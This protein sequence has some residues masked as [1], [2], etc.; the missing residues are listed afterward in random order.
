MNKFDLVVIGG[1]P[2]GYP[3]AI[4]MAKKG[5][6][7]A[8]VERSGEV[9]GTC[10]KWGCIPTKALLASAKG[11]HFL[12]TAEEFGLKSNDIGFD[13]DKIQERKIGIT[14]KLQIGIIKLLKKYKVTVFEGMAKLYK[15][16]KVIIENEQKTEIFG[17]RVCVCVGSTPFI[18]P[19]FP[20]NKDLFWS[21]NEALEAK[22]IP[23]KLLIVGGGVIGME[24]GQVFNEFG[25]K[26]TVVEMLPHIL[27][28]FDTATTKRL[29]PVF[30]KMGIEIFT[31]TKVESLEE[32]NGKPLA[33]FG[34]E[35]R[36]FDRVLIATGR[37]VNDLF[38][39]GTDL[40]LEIEKGVLKV[41][42]QFLTSEEGVY[43][44]GDAIHGPMLAHKASYDA[45][46]LSELFE[47]KKIVVDYS[48]I[49]G[50]VFTYPEIAWVGKME[51][52][53]K[54][55][56]VPY[57][58]GRSMFSANGKAL[59]AGKS[60]GQTKVFIG[61]SGKVLGA[62]IWGTEASNL[63]SEATIMAKLGIKSHELL[64]VIHPHPTLSE[65]YLD[66]IENALGVSVNS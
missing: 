42:E 50:C 34:G 30:K 28:G 49:P 13:W 9:G 60:D 6:N 54:E 1:G 10:L 31:N 25:S 55:E 51:D 21:S 26:V 39:Q 40:E 48:V 65:I 41:D 5:W 44:I 56:G 58:V 22:E 36:E 33:T 61:D 2:G 35:I 59:T 23:E 11:F 46:I 3:L 19:V 37:R 16:R 8:L 27:S 20:Q 38:L 17:D 66:A 18:P 62:V 43:A 63:L 64:D 53:L 15:N 47:G 57:T 12:K 32:K 52:Q 29:L 4:R 24:L 14:N 7:V 45:H